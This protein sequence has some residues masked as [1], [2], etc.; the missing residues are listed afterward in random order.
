GRLPFDS[1]TGSLEVLLA[2]A[3]QRKRIAVEVSVIH[4]AG[5]VVEVT[6]PAVIADGDGVEADSTAFLDTRP[7]GGGDG[8]VVTIPAALEEPSEGNASQA[9]PV[10]VSGSLRF[11]VLPDVHV[12]CAFGLGPVGRKAVEAILRIRPRLVIQTGDFISATVSSDAECVEKMQAAALSR[13]VR[14]I[15]DAGIDFFHIAGNHDVVGAAKQ[16]YAGFAASLPGPAV[17]GPRGRASYYSFDVGDSH[18]VALYAPGTNRLSAEQME[19]LREDLEQARQNGAKR[20]FTFAH[21]PLVAPAVV[22]G[23]TSK[24][25]RNYLASSSELM[26]LLREYGVTHF[27]G[28][29]HVFADRESS[30]VRDAIAGMVGG[31]KG[32]LASLGAY[33]PFTFSVVDVSGTDVRVTRVEWPDFAFEPG[34]AQAAVGDGPSPQF[35]FSEAECPVEGSIVAGFSPPQRL[36]SGFAV[37]SGTTVLVPFDATVA[38]AGEAGGCG[39]AV[40]LFHGLDAEGRGVYTGYCY[41]SEVSVRNGARVSKG[42]AIGKSGSGEGSAQLYLKLHFFSEGS[43]VA[44][45]ADAFDLSRNQ[46]VDPMQYFGKCRAG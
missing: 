40:E 31:G 29:I 42:Q 12:E 34:V 11:V 4:D 14:P 9:Q 21:S 2:E 33:Q 39:K 36:G 25:E 5:G 44:S 28:H 16:L 8:D 20:F 18:F 27:A 41:L 24:P 43:G 32:R 30:G 37:P 1:K 35:D 15:V 38:F 10:S 7:L 22:R 3:V 23:S 6:D 45:A 46:F 19:W 13:V 26:D 17:N